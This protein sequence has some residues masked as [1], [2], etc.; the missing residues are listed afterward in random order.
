MMKTKIYYTAIAVITT[1]VGLAMTLIPY[2]IM[3]F[4]EAESG[5]MAAFMSR[6]FGIPMI[7]FA[8]IYFLSR[9][10]TDS[11][12]QTTLTLAAVICTGLLSVSTAY[13]MVTHLIGTGGI[14]AIVIE[15][16][17]AI[18]GIIV[19]MKKRKLN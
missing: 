7:V 9:N 3:K 1:V 14:V 16:I 6:R 12:V 11:K 10:S 8:V 13:G 4:W 15:A 19:L 5:D 17:L 2:E 18:W